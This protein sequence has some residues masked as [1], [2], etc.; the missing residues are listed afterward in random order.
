MNLSIDLGAVLALLRQS[1]MFFISSLNLVEYLSFLLSCFEIRP[2]NA[3]CILFNKLLNARSDPR[4]SF[5]FF[6][7]YNK[8]TV[9]LTNQHLMFT[10]SK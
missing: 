5:F 4:K 8:L 6:F 9:S 2:S 7:F 10:S 3:I 1:M